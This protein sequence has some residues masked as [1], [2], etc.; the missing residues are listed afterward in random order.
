[1]RLGRSKR[2]KKR[3]GRR[4]S[5]DAKKKK[6]GKEKSRRKRN[7]AKYRSLISTGRKAPNFPATTISSEGRKKKGKLPTAFITPIDIE[8]RRR[9]GRGRGG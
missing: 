3:A 4:A 5:L 9:G 6:K 7:L 2:D 8:K 1:L